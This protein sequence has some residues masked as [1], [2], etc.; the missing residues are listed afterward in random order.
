LP[1]AGHDRPARAA[2]RDHALATAALLAIAPLALVLGAV[3]GAL[4]SGLLPRAPATVLAAIPHANAAISL[5]AIATIAS[6]WRWIRDGQVRRH[7]AA[8][9][10]ATGLFATFLGLYL[11]RLVILGTTAFPGPEP[12]YRWLYL[13]VL[14]VHITLAIVCIPLLYCVL[15]I[16]LTHP[17]SA[18]PRTPH[19][20]VAR[21]AASLW[22]VSFALGS[23]VYLLLYV[24]Y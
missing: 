19:R 12:V 22:L 23:V 24:V 4:P 9:V 18:I 17:V 13:P 10:T 15:L 3:L 8:M 20:R 16:G 7:R 21:V 6:G 14:A 11:Y 1:E 5:V 2:L